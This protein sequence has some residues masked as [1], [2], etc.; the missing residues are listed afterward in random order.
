MKIITL[1][2]NHDA[3]VCVW[4]NGQLVQVYEEQ[5]YT[6]RK[7][8]GDPIVT[9]QRAIKE[10]GWPDILG[11]TMTHTTF[12]VF[13]MPY[14]KNNFYLEYCNKFKKLPKVFIHEINC[15][16]LWHS[17]CSYH[18]SELGKNDEETL[19]FVF[20]GA[21]SVMSFERFI[22]EANN[23]LEY[24]GAESYSVYVIKGDQSKCLYKHIQCLT[25]VP[26]TKDYW[27]NLKFFWR[28]VSTNS[29]KFIDKTTP[30][31]LHEKTENLSNS[32][33]DDDTMMDFSN[34]ISIGKLYESIT[35]LVGFNSQSDA[36]KTMGLASYGTPAYKLFDES[37]RPRQD[38]FSY[39]NAIGINNGIIPDNKELS[40]QV[41]ANLAASVQEC[42]ENYTQD[43]IK[44][45][46][47]KTQIK[48]V[49]ITG[50][51]A[52]NVI[53][54]AKIK[55]MLGPKINFWAEPI[56]NDG[57][58]AIG[59][60]YYLS[61]KFA[62][63]QPKFNIYTHKPEILDLNKFKK[64][65]T[66]YDKIVQD[67]LNDEI[68]GIF[69]ENIAE[70]GPRALGNKSILFNP[71]TI[72]GKEIV[73]KFKNREFF[74]P[75]AGIMLEEHFQDWFET[76]GL[77][78]SPYMMHGLIVKSN[79]KGLIPSIVHEDNTCRIQTVNPTQNKFMY[80]LLLEWYKISNLPILLNTSLNLS[81]EAIANSTED[82]LMILDTKM[83]KYIWLP[84]QEICIS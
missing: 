52:L 32:S 43:I 6:N 46:T 50:G 26:N 58:T 81:G 78:S 64:H 84:N 68:I 69:D 5:R 56:A 37:N 13:K 28:D 24:S 33:Y 62:N 27:R 36:G 70:I 1:N 76:N 74:R 4:D 60:G 48:N 38:I 35:D 31:S 18:N 16:H 22:P 67:L 8:D 21:G 7:H 51:V 20:D 55:K 54:N 66:G 44:F 59:L 83:I 47:E 39:V 63:N 41:K 15:H 45:W 11:I 53:N 73:N 34:H 80:D 9:Y 75:F 82:L 25:N 79:K 12:D 19:C 40:F 30:Y 42:L 23:N 57:G 2:E 65:K 49:I 10:H 17:Y 72:N 14:L 77:S 3:S 61:R 71:A 29:I